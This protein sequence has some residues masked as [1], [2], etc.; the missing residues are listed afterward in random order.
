MLKI[1]LALLV[2]LQ[3]FWCIHLLGALMLAYSRHHSQSL[4]ASQ[5]NTA[6]ACRRYAEVAITALCLFATMGWM[7][8][9]I[10]FVALTWIESTVGIAGTNE[11]FIALRMSLKLFYF[12]SLASGITTVPIVCF[13][14]KLLLWPW[15]IE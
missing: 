11:P 2:A 12:W 6:I 13:F 4:R 10:H 3:C 8:S 15:K 9:T 14:T 5:S 7:F 1:S